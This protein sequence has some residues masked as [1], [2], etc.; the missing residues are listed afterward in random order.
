MKNTKYQTTIA[1]A[2]LL[3]NLSRT[4]VGAMSLQAKESTCDNYFDAFD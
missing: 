2:A 1:L 4:E 3:S